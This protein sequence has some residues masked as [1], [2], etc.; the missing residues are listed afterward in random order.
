[1]VLKKVISACEGQLTVYRQ[2]CRQP[3]FIDQCGG[4][5]GRMKASAVD[6]DAL[7]ECAGKLSAG[8]P[9]HD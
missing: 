1:M 8:C 6:S 9:L 3:G 7:R 5:P 4:N 2:A